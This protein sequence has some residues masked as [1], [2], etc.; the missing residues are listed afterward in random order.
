MGE[1]HKNENSFLFADV[2]IFYTYGLGRPMSSRHISQSTRI[3]Q[4]MRQH[5]VAF[6]GEIPTSRWGKG[7]EAMSTAIANCN[8]AHDQAGRS[9]TCGCKNCTTETYSDV[10]G[11]LSIFNCKYCPT[12]SNTGC[13]TYFFFNF[14][15]A[16]DVITVRLIFVN[17]YH[18]IHT[19]C[20]T[21]IQRHTHTCAHIWSAHKRNGNNQSQE[22][23]SEGRK[24]G[25]LLETKA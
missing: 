14:D 19:H 4:G 3:L 1:F 5:C 22:P 10:P 12:N 24:K 21:H 18:L 8:S 25:F 16:R 2:S 13:N 9:D 17:I 20:H 7:P 15:I 6:C 11:I 23:V